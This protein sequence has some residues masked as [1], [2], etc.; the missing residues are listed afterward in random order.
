ML[1]NYIIVTIN[2]IFEKNIEILIFVFIIY[3]YN[4]GL[5]IFIVLYKML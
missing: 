4:Y 5:K 2:I 1:R 3:Q